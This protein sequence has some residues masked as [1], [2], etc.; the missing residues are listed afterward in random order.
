MATINYE[1]IFEKYDLKV[2]SIGLETNLM[3]CN[4]PE[5]SL[6]RPF[7]GSRCTRCHAPSTLLWDNITAWASKDN[8]F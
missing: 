1:H 5:D 8:F 7:P 2:E 3:V 6:R 4:N